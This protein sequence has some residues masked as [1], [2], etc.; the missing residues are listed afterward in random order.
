MNKRKAY[1]SEP[2]EKKSNTNKNKGLLVDEKTNN[3]NNYHIQ[4]KHK[5]EK[6]MKKNFSFNNMQKENVENN[7]KEINS[8]NILSTNNDKNRCIIKHSSMKY[9][10]ITPIINPLY[11]RAYFNTK[12]NLQTANNMNQHNIYLDKVIRNVNLEETPS[13]SRKSQTL[14]KIENMP[15]HI[16][17]NINIINNN[18]V[19]GNDIKNENIIF[20]KKRIQSCQKTSLSKTKNK[21]NN[22]IE[23]EEANKLYIKNNDKETNYQLKK[24][25][26]ENYYTK[27]Y[28]LN[29]FN[30]TNIR[31]T[32]PNINLLDNKSDQNKNYLTIKNIKSKNNK[33]TNFRN[34][35]QKDY[36]TTNNNKYSEN[37]EKEQKNLMNFKELN[38]EDF[39]LIIQKFNDIKINIEYIYS[40]YNLNYEQNYVST[41]KILKLNNTNKIK[42]Y[43]LFL[44]FMGSSFDGSPEKLFQDKKFKY[45]LHIWTII[46]IIS[47]GILF[48]VMQNVNLT[49]QCSQDILK[50]ITLQEKIFLIFC[51]LVIKKLSKK[52]K[53]NIWVEQII[54]ILNE[55]S[56]F[57]VQNQ[58]IVIRTFIINSYEIINSLLL[59]IKNFDSHQNIIIK[60]NSN[61]LYNNFYNVDWKNLNEI[62]INNIE[63][64][65]NQYI[66]RVFNTNNNY[67]KTKTFKKS[68]V[69]NNINRGY[70]T[71][72][73][74]SQT[75]NTSPESSNKNKNSVINIPKKTQ[76]K[77]LLKNS[78]SNPSLTKKTKNINIK[79]Q[80]YV[81]STIIQYEII[82]PDTPCPL[83]TP[84]IPFLNFPQKKLYTLVMDL[85][86][87][88]SSFK[89]TDVKTGTGILYLRPNLEN[90][91]EVIKDYYEIIPFT[92]AS[93]DY[94]DIALDLIEKNE[95][96]KYFEK[97]LYREHT[98]QFGK[99]YIKDLSKLGR[100]LSKVIIVDNLSQCFKLNTENGILIN[101]FFGEDENDK[102]LIELQKILIKI[103]YDSDDVRKG[104]IKYKYDIFN[105]ISKGSQDDEN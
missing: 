4:T 88:M 43:D 31:R 81:N 44:F 84:S 52:Y 42:L 24:N 66:F 14:N 79:P 41:K 10:K 78:N 56:S 104:L 58:I 37:K 85:D 64:N 38:L 55:K 47:I 100:D 1:T 74:I 50:L 54:K 86:E 103:Y 82:I 28:K 7:A 68:L 51:D 62:T 80:N 89:F 13:S 92:S 105:K 67:I 35:S 102:A 49:D 17:N 96:K 94:A 91:L 39:L 83:V 71:N 87:T 59:A 65:F 63:E 57:N 5:I 29:L 12:I 19:N 40:F 76:N 46:F 48:T 34:I 21:K 26:Y 20:M 11:D 99:K 15:I 33:N 25:I 22:K 70:Y 16:M 18:L 61:F 75:K 53:C 72:N 77:I 30:K 98:T 45:Y 93:R 90:F 97:R 60:N 3:F 8:Q 9:F 23:L 101:S 69:K 2:N 32:K 36:N 73:R 95:R 6:Y 27:N